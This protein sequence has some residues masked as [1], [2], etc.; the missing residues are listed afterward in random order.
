MKPFIKGDHLTRIDPAEV[1]RI[2][3]ATP[4]YRDGIIEVQN[5]FNLTVEAVRFLLHKGGYL[6]NS[7]SGEGEPK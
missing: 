6:K 1:V 2:M 5:R 4:S 7:T 3:D